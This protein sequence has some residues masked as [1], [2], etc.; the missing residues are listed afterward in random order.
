MR[1]KEQMLHQAGAFK[2]NGGSLAFVKGPESDL[3]SLV[4][5]MFISIKS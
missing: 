3:G 2:E 4:A 5:G 1:G